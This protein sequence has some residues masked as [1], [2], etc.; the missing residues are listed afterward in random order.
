MEPKKVK[1][2]F[3]T[4]HEQTIDRMQLE[5]AQR[6]RERSKIWKNFFK[7]FDLPRNKSFPFSKYFSIILVGTFSN[8]NKHR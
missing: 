2:L 7:W 4:A 8:I 3:C 1:Q 6:S 5:M